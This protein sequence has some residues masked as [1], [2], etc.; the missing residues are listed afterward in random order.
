[1]HSTWWELRTWIEALSGM[2]SEAGGEPPVPGG[3][4]GGMEGYQG[5]PLN[6]FNSFKP[7]DFFCL[8]GFF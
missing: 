5:K 4:R 3:S 7:S 6:G 2:E 1:M 8:F